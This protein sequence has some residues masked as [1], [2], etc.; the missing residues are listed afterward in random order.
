MEAK[1]WEGKLWVVAHA[2]GQL[3]SYGNKTGPRLF[4]NLADAKEFRDRIEARIV[5]LVRV[6]IEPIA[7]PKV[8]GGELGTT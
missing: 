5:L 7:D 1:K 3:A 6:T 4:K 2:N 8:Q